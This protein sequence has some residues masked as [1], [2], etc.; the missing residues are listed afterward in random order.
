MGLAFLVTGCAQPANIPLGGSP[1]PIDTPILVSGL[2]VFGKNETEPA[3][4][5]LNVFHMRKRR[6][7]RATPHSARASR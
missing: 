2:P 6:D 7:P 3:P 1:G 4:L 5:K